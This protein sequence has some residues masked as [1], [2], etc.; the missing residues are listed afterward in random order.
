MGNIH[1]FSLAWR[2][3]QSTHAVF[4]D[5]VLAQLRPIDA[6]EA[7]E[8]AKRLRSSIDGN[9]LAVDSFLTIQKE[10][11][12][13]HISSFLEGLGIDD[14]TIVLLSWD[15]GTALRT[16]WGIFRQYWDDFC[17]PSSDDVAIAPEADSWLLSYSHEEAFEFGRR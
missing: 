4:P 12:R 8:L 5:E 3:T 11:V 17:Y 6:P 10:E 9:S 16:S 14:M 13:E 1:Q 7:N 2:W 15:S